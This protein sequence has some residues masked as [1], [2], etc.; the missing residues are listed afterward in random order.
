MAP[1]YGPYTKSSKMLK[2]Q[3]FCSMS[4]DS[5]KKKNKK[6]K[7]KTTKI[8]LLIAFVLDNDKSS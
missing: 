3:N 8:N 1:Y 5:K 2:Y 7:N 6:K 4:V